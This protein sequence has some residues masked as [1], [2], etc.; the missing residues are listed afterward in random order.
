MVMDIINTQELFLVLVLES[1]ACKKQEN[2]GTEITSWKPRTVI[3]KVTAI[4]LSTS[5]LANVIFIR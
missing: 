2:D 3:V 5:G 1:E 4:V